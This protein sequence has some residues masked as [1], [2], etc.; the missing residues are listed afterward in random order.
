MGRGETAVACVAI[1]AFSQVRRELLGFG[2]RNVAVTYDSLVIVRN[3]KGA[4]DHVT[5]A[6]TKSDLRQAAEFTS[7]KRQM[8]E[9]HAKR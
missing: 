1:L 9:A 2:G 6:A 4:I 8:A 5:I 7:L 3:P